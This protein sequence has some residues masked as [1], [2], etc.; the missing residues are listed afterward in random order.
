MG[1]KDIE[2]L[3]VDLEIFPGSGD[4]ILEVESEGRT[5]RMKLS[6]TTLFLCGC[7]LFHNVTLVSILHSEKCSITPGQIQRKFLTIFMQNILINSNTTF[8]LYLV[9]CD[10]A[11]EVTVTVPQPFLNKMVQVDEDSSGLVTLDYTYMITEKEVTSKVISV[12]SDEAISVIGFYT[13]GVTADAMACLPEE[14]LGTEYY[15]ITPWVEIGGQVSGTRRQFA[16]AN[17]SERE[18]QVTIKVSGSIIY[19]GKSYK[20]GH[21][22][23][24]LLG[25][26]KV[27]Q[28]R[29]SEDLTGT[30]ISSSAPV[31]VFAG[32][33]CYKG[34]HSACDVLIEQL[35]PVQNWGKVFAVFP[36]LNHTQD[37]I[38]IV[39]GSPD[40]LVFIKSPEGTTQRNLHEGGHVQ[41]IVDKFLLINATNPVMVSYLAQQSRSAGIKYQYDP[42]TTTV[43]PSFLGKRYYKFVTQSYYDNFIL[44]VFQ[45]SSDSGFSL[46]GKPL[47]SYPMSMREFNGFRGW[48]VTLGKSEGQHEIYHKSSIFT[49]YVYGIGP[50]VS[51]GY[52]MGQGLL[53][54]EPQVLQSNEEEECRLRCLS[55]GAEYTLPL[56]LV[57]EATLDVVDIHLQDPICRVELD[58]NNVI[59]K[60]PF[61]GC[62]SKV[63]Y[64]DRRTFYAN[65]IYGTIPDTDVH[66]IEIPVRCEMHG[67]KSVELLINPKVNNVICKG[68]YNVSMQLYQ[69]DSFTE[70][71]TLYPRELDLHSSLHVEFKVVSE[72]KG[73][74][75]LTETL[76]ASPAPENTTRK[77]TV[78]QNG[79]HQDSTLQVHQVDDPRLQRFTF[80]TFKFDHFHEVY[81]AAN[82]IICHNATSPNR[83]TKGC[84]SPRLRRGVHASMEQLDTVTLSQGPIVFRSKSHG[85]ILFPVLSIIL[86]ILLLVTGLGLIIQ[87]E[88]YRRKMAALHGGAGHS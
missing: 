8:Q 40:T 1:K 39:A 68:Y 78:I 74:Q 79:C 26:H 53:N 49:L 82:V 31:A 18:V 77:Y 30:K 33:S 81:L 59:I 9:T 11:A 88:Y 69:S 52:S 67:N 83:C 55:H 22:F 62:G 54:Q 20:S 85:Y 27:I 14:D 38:S 58:G 65:T 63:L 76:T 7:N 15:I 10:K 25:N 17:G 72:E 19:N 12:I 29:S 36:F 2:K 32:H 35:H 48:Q 4:F 64:E 56:S 28:F 87:K 51:F 80:H 37:V 21:S 23:S 70:P 66:R 47:S 84:I 45:T 71:L 46:D 13:A 5:V 60:I 42:F 43:P 41:I 73:L 16:V 57:S 44:I 86:G 24:L 50:T 3:Q 6:L 34:S 61:I 75:I